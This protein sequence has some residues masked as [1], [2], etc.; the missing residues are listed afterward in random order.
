[1]P[2]ATEI[3]SVVPSGTDA[4]LEGRVMAEVNRIRVSK[5][6]GVLKRHAGLDKLA[7]HHSQ[8]MLRDG[9]L[10]HKGY[11][12]RAGLAEHRLQ[13]DDL[14]ENVFYS[15]GIGGA[16]LPARTVQGWWDSKAHRLNLL[17]NTHYCGIGVAQDDEGRYYATQL[18][19]K[20]LN[21]KSFYHEGMPKSYSNVYGV[22]SGGGEW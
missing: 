10:S 2:T 6:K 17:A 4:S 1:M 3:S 14:R 18:L 22:G 12:H 15:R 7:R 11:H 21:V 5:N 13:V 19:A 16:E 8:R 20:P 9:K